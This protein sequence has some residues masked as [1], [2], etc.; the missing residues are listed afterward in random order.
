MVR[1]GT[2][3]PWHDVFIVFVVIESQMIEKSLQLQ[4]I[5]RFRQFFA[6]QQAELAI[7]TA[8]T[9]AT[10]HGQRSWISGWINLVYISMPIS[11]ANI[12]FW[13]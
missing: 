11:M 7:D 3:P 8:G 6:I 2:V 1:I 12:T 13:T 10:V 9:V 4:Q 5:F